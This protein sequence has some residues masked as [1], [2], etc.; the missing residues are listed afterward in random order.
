MEELIVE[1]KDAIQK[2]DLGFDECCFVYDTEI[3][4]KCRI[5][6]VIETDVEVQIFYD[7]DWSVSTMTIDELWTQFCAVDSSKPVVFINK[8]TGE[9][10]KSVGV[11]DCL[12]TTID[13]NV[14][15]EVCTPINKMQVET[16]V[17]NHIDD[18]FYAVAKRFEVSKYQ[19]P[20]EE[21]APIKK[22]IEELLAQC[23]HG[24]QTYSRGLVKVEGM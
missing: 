13:F 14:E 19:M 5:A 18:M 2:Q 11:D 22:Q 12:G 16:Y 24:E 17:S 8:E 4:D 1:F 20:N 10:K 15:A 21:L 6:E 3:E 7:E 23:F 9:R